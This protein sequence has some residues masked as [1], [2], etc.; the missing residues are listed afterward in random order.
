MSARDQINRS[1]SRPKLLSTDRA[2][3][4]LLLLLAV[5]LHDLK[6]D[7]QH[8]FQ[9]LD[10]STDHAL[11]VAECLGPTQKPFEDR[12]LVVE[13][14]GRVRNYWGRKRPLGERTGAPVVFLG[15]GVRVA[16][17]RVGGATGRRLNEFSASRDT[18]ECERW[19]E[20]DKERGTLLP[21]SVI[22][23]G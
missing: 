5:L 13:P 17:L 18:V 3:P 12:V 10:P 8:I 7:F 22:T 6:F 9:A 21:S 20:F 14:A 11:A 15:L 2:S 1:N 19:R 23:H 4:P 16:E